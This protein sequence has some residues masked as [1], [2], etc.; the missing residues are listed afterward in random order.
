MKKTKIITAAVLAATLLMGAG[1]ASWTSNVNIKHNITTGFM[2]VQFINPNYQE[3]EVTADTYVQA[4]VDRDIHDVTFTLNNLYPG[5]KYQTLT[6]EKNT[7]SIGVA[8]DNAVVTVDNKSN[9]ELAK[10][11]IVSFDCWVF[12]KDGKHIES[13]KLPV[14]ADVSLSN[15]AGALN[16]ALKDVKLEPGQSLK[17]K[18]KSVD[19]QSVDQ[20]MT[21]T[22]KDGANLDNTTQK[23]S[24]SFTI[25]LN[26][27]QFNK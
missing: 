13:I 11:T 6:E 21:F 26:W 27:K 1:Y 25:Q 23:Q 16:A 24:L 2:D 20:L 9:A 8:F 7:G 3:A 4:S 22:L 15:L 17:L 5:A 18:G 10:N 12:D 14:Q 19:Q